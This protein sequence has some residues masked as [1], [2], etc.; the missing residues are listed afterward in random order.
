[1]IR[2]L[3]AVFVAA[4]ILPG[5][6]LTKEDE[7]KIREGGEN[8]QKLALKPI[9]TYPSNE[10]VVDKEIDVVARLD[11]SKSYSKV[12]LYVNGQPVS[13]L[14]DVVVT[15]GDS[16]RSFNWD[17]YYWSQENKVT[18]FVE[19]IVNDDVGTTAT[20]D[21]V[22]I[23]LDTNVK[24]T[25]AVIDLPANN[26]FQNV[27]KAELAWTEKTN[28][29]GYDVR[30][31]SGEV[32]DYGS[33]SSNEL[34]LP[35]IGDY[36]ISLRAYKTINN[37]KYFG[38]WTDTQ[39]VTLISPNAPTLEISDPVPTNSLWSVP[40]GFAGQLV[41]TELLI[42][43]DELGQNV[44]VNESLSDEG[45]TAELPLG[46]Y[47]AKARTTNEFGHQSEWSEAQEFNVGLFSQAL[48]ITQ[49]S[50]GWFSNGTNDQPAALALTD[51]E[52]VIASSISNSARGD[53]SGD[54][55]GD[56]HITYLNYEGEVTGSQSNSHI[57]RGVLDLQSNGSDIIAVV[58]GDDW[59]KSHILDVG[60]NEST[61]V[62]KSFNRLDN[63]SNN[64]TAAY[65]Y[66]DGSFIY[67][68]NKRSWDCNPSCVSTY[69]KS[70]VM[71]NQGLETEYVVYEGGTSSYRDLDALLVNDAGVYAAGEYYSAS[72]GSSD[73]YGGPVNSGAYLVELNL[74]SQVVSEPREESGITNASNIKLHAQESAIVATYKNSETQVVS[75]F[76]DSYIDTNLLTFTLG[77]LF[78]L[79]NGYGVL[80]DNNRQMILNEFDSDGNGRNQYFEGNICFNNVNIIEVEQHEK[81]GLIVLA[82]DGY[83]GSNHTIVFNMTKNGQYICPPNQPASL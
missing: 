6:N 67:T 25:I 50:L 82:T 47:F 57:A 7:Q 1:M 45:T 26:Q 72:D 3:T 74:D 22:T 59:S 34:Q 75:R 76:L 60:R 58:K 70:I 24:N 48:D 62:L 64:A 15:Q 78:L 43:K 21:V 63:E 41:S 11:N 40:V 49:V 33:Q 18:L 9:I 23:N 12:T 53:G 54:N 10:I 8:A 44:V 31:S 66:D 69:K 52:L 73:I 19:A 36:E 80:S 29:D 81:Y 83:D 28:S 46:Q 79:E 39:L 42:S 14:A 16:N 4:I 38:G 71:D 5:C 35:N 37:K 68:H 2:F 51:N 65:P 13:S 20:S 61:V 17:P 77:E 32:I 55:F 27:D 56:A 30:L